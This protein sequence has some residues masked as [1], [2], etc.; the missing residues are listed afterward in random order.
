M[1]T[2]SGA[3]DRVV[4]SSDFPLQQNQYRSSHR[5][6]QAFTGFIILTICWSSGDADPLGLLSFKQWYFFIL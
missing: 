5:L 6:F 2:L 3:P 4:I 1:L